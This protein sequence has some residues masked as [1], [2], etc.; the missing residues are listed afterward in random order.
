MHFPDL[1]H[2]PP[3]THWGLHTFLGVDSARWLLTIR[4]LGPENPLAHWHFAGA[5]QT[6]PFLQPPRQRAGE[7]EKFVPINKTTRKMRGRNT[8]AWCSSDLSTLAG[9]CTCSCQHTA[10]RAFSFG[11]SYFKNFST[12]ENLQVRLHERRLTAEEVFLPSSDPTISFLLS[13]PGSPLTELLGLSKAGERRGATLASKTL[14]IGI[15]SLSS[16]HSLLPS[17]QCW[18]ALQ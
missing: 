2:F 18:C 17:L 4:Q 16:S 9:T 11:I 10:R 8:Y 12:V 5:T 15:S 3:F 14:P 1:L 13:H 6:P 7:N